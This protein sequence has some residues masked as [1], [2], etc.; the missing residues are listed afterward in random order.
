MSETCLVQ[1]LD[2]RHHRRRFRHRSRILATTHGTSVIGCPLDVSDRAAVRELVDQTV[3]RDGRIDYFFNNAGISLGGP[4]N[5]MSGAHWDLII[6]TNIMGVVNGLLAVYPLMIDQG[7]GHII[8]TASAAGL[9]PPPFVAA[10]AA[11]KHAVVGLSTGLRPEAALHGVRISVLCPG[12]LRDVSRNRAVSVVRRSAMALW[13]LQRPSPS[14]TQRVLMS[15]AKIIGGTGL[16][17]QLHRS[18]SR[19]PDRAVRQRC[20]AGWRSSVADS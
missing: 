12:A 11:T 4:T 17:P 7:H 8:T 6:Q 3:A 9:V 19:R 14:V 16:G 2:G 10:Y 13:Y 15:M 1:W 5:E 18:P 20:I